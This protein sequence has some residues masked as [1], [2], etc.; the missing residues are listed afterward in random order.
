MHS[1]IGP[2]LLIAPA[3]AFWIAIPRPG[4]HFILCLAGVSILA[5]WLIQRYV[6]AQP[7]LVYALAMGIVIANQALGALTG[8][9]I[10]NHAPS[11]LVVLPGGARHLPRGVPLGSSWSYHRAFVAEQ[12]RT[13]AFAKRVRNACDEKTLVLSLNATQIFSDLYEAS[14]PWNAEKVALHRFP[15]LAAHIGG[16]TV[17]VLSEN[18]G[19]PHDA[20]G[21]VLAD[22]AFRDYK[23][24]RDPNNVSIYDH[25]VIPPNRIAHL[26]CAP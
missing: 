18:E 17:L 14:T 15:I 6:P 3:L 1:A 5:A 8:P 10:L 11:K 23:L 2:L 12:L 4:R 7:L 24:V 19:W 13:T 22:P 25:A 26:D 9:F 21:D 20:A 16:R